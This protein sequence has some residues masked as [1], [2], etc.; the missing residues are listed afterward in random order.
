MTGS[1]SPQRPTVTPS[2]SPKLMRRIEADNTDGI[3]DMERDALNGSEDSHRFKLDN[4]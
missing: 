3:D 2:T 1:L 4:S